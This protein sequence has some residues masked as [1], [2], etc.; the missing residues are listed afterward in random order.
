MFSD[1][2]LTRPQGVSEFA[3]QLAELMAPGSTPGEASLKNNKYDRWR[4]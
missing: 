4:N 1:K 3:S 2:N